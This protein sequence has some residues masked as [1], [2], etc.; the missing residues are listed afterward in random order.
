MIDT[1]EFL[2]HVRVEAEILETWVE[3]GWLL[4]SRDADVRRFSDADMARAQLI[5]DL[6]Q[7]LGV[8]EEG[9]SI[10]L[11]LIDQVHGLRRTLRELLAA[12]S[13]EPDAARQRIVATIRGVVSNRGEPNGA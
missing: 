4:P 10:I 7:D 12:V 8:N 1:S 11:D 3:A 9:V 6:Q 5:R 2:T 13:Q